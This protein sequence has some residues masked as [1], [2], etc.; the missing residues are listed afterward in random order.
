MSYRQ[1]SLTQTAAG[2]KPPKRQPRGQRIPESEA[3]VQAAIIERLTL[4]GY[5][6]VSTSRIRKGVRCRCGQWL[7][8]SGGDGVTKGCPDLFVTHHAWPPSMWVAIEVKGS[9]TPVSDEQRAMIQQERYFVARDQ[10]TAHQLLVEAE[11]VIL[12]K[13]HGRTLETS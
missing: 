2:G 8:P 3:Q 13:S 11:T 10:D 7:V 6:V 9:H 5:T 12:G 4:A 1:L